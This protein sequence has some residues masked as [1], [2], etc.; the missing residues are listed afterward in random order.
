MNALGYAWV[1]VST[2]VQVGKHE[3][4]MS[5]MQRGVYVVGGVHPQIKVA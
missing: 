3:D 4:A 1:P 5:Y 2:V